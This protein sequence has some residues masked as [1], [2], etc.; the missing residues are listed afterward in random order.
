MVFCRI[1]VCRSWESGP[2]NRSAP[3]FLQ[4]HVCFARKVCRFAMKGVPLGLQ[5]T[6][7]GFAERSPRVAKRVTSYHTVRHCPA[8]HCLKTHH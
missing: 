3:I 7:S 4:Q 1:S 5:E 8:C 2:R 6:I